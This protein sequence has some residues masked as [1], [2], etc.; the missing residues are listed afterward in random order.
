MRRMW[1]LVLAVLSAAA[2]QPASEASDPAAA[3]AALADQHVGRILEVLR[4]RPSNEDDNWLILG[5]ARLS[6]SW[7]VPLAGGDSRVS[8]GTVTDLDIVVV[9]NSRVRRGLDVRV[10]P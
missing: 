9:G 5:E 6:T 4:A 7:S 8:G 2:C 3:E 10:P 1:L